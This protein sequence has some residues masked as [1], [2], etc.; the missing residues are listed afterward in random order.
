M[1]EQARVPTQPTYHDTGITWKVLTGSR[2][3][4][5]TLQLLQ[6]GLQSV[7]GC[8]LQPPERAALWLAEAGL[9]SL[10]S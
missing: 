2:G 5:H 8:Y 6:R 4:G 1:P 10:S 7:C 9:L 3:L